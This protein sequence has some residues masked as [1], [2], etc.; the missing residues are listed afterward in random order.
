VDY[1]VDRV[2]DEMREAATCYLRPRS[3]ALA[4]EDIWEKSPG[5]VV[6]VADQECEKALSDRLCAAVPGSVVIGE[7][8]AA[9]DPSLLRHLSGEQPVWLLDPLAQRA[10]VRDAGAA[11][12]CCQHRVPRTREG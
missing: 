5:E 8:A 1:D 3:R 9:E 2:V 11:S 10:S 12:D 4:T 7:E 6:T